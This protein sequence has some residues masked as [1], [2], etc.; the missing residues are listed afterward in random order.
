M[1]KLPSPRKSAK[2][3]WKAAVGKDEWEG[4]VLKMAAIE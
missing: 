2:N 3:M 1:Q 4:A